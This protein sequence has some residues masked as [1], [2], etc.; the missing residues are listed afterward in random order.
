MKPMN[1][2]RFPLLIL[3]FSVALLPATF[4]CD[5]SDPPPPVDSGSD[6]GPDDAG[7]DTAVDADVPACPV[8]GQ[9]AMPEECNAFDDDCDGLMDEGVCDD[10]CDVFDTP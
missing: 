5:P 3:L 1:Y 9:V 6:T 8:F 4:A 7:A 2:R 10:P